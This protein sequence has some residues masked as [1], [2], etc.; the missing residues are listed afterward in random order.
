MEVIRTVNDDQEQIILDI[1]KL[2]VPSGRI[3]VDPTYSKGVFYKGL[4]PA[5]QHK[6]DL[7][8]QTEDTIQA[9]ADKL[10]LADKFVDCIMFDPPFVI[11]SGPSLLEDKVGQ[12][13]THTRFGSFPTVQ[14]L[15]AF[16]DEALAE[17]H[18]VLK[19]KG[20]VIFK[21]QDTVSSGRNYMSHCEIYNMASEQGFYCKDLF[22]LTAKSRINSFGG[23]WHTQ[24]HARKYHSYFWVLE[25]K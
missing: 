13:M 25:K 21:C 6:F 17:F 4:V 5:P 23:K 3:D 1:L 11:S 2:H 19:D 22:I 16:Y 15:W 10:P 24:R 8:P 18:R 12:N 20:I 7:Y 9:S 14:A